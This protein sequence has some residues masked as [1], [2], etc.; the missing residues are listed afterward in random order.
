MRGRVARITRFPVK[1]MGGESLSSA[2]L[3]LDGLP[4]DRAW[5]LRDSVRGDLF[6]GKRSGR[7]MACSSAASIASA[8]EA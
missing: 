1:S 6:L 5:A 8:L 3:G 4:G 2:F 7:V